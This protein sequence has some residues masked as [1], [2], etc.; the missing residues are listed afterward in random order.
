MSRKCK[1]CGN[2]FAPRFKTTERYCAKID[3][4]VAKGM[5]HVHKKREKLA[6]DR[7]SVAKAISEK[8]NTQALKYLKTNTVTM[9]HDFIKL[10]DKGKPCVSCGEPW[11]K[12]HQAGHWKSASKYANLKFDERNIQNQCIGCNI[13]KQGNIEQYS[14]R[15]AQR[16]GEDAKAELEQLARDHMQNGFKW[17]ALELRRIRDYYRNKLNELKN[18]TK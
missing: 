14:D 8:Q 11:H 9:C 16:I 7:E 17:D 5:E 2:K 4:Q 6:K 3:C 1:H 15:I 10:R 12:D 13:H 18:T